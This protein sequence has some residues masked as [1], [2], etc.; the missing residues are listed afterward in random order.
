MIRSRLLIRRLSALDWS[1][2]PFDYRF[3]YYQRF[4]W[5]QRHLHL[6]TAYGIFRMKQRR[7]VPHRHI[8]VWMMKL[9]RALKT[10]FG[11]F[12][13]FIKEEYEHYLAHRR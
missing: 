7:S 4:V 10:A 9:S 13:S 8:S 11:R 12:V 5:K 2:L 6:K 3:E 1:N